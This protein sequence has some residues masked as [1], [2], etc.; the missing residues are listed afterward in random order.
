MQREHRRQS[1]LGNLGFSFFDLLGQQYFLFTTEER[2][3]LHLAEIGNDRVGCL[4]RGFVVEAAS[5]P[6]IV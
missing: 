1:L 5:Q 2:D 4:T 6:C 3:R